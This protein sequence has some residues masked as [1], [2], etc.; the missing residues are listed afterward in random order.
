MGSIAYGASGAAAIAASGH[1]AA[2]ALM[3]Q[4]DINA[5]RDGR[6]SPFCTLL[7]ALGVRVLQLLF[8]FFL[9]PINIWFM[10]VAIC[11]KLTVSIFIWSGNQK[12]AQYLCPLWRAQVKKKKKATPPQQ[13][14]DLPNFFYCPWFF[15]Q[16]ARSCVFNSKRIYKNGKGGDTYNAN[17]CQMF[18]HLFT[19]FIQMLLNEFWNLLFGGYIVGVTLTLLCIPLRDCIYKV[20]EDDRFVMF[21]HVVS[22]HS[23]FIHIWMETREFLSC[24]GKAAEIN[25]S[26]NTLSETEGLTSNT[27]S[28]DKAINQQTAGVKFRTGV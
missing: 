19:A 7:F 1:M 27:N 4:E 24:L 16:D 15:V 28:L 14:E 9:M 3:R 25:I 12:I 11:M 21:C 13:T 8:G 20:T 10:F 17:G 5:S 26:E 18:L 23:F 6:R 2:S 22:D